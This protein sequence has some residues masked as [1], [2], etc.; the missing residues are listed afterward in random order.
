[1]DLFERT[2][3]KIVEKHAAAGEFTCGTLFVECAESTVETIKDEIGKNF[4]LPHMLVTEQFE[5]ADGVF[6][7][8]IDF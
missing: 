6:E 8:S 3:L 2:V 5:V 4:V 1:M 7:Y